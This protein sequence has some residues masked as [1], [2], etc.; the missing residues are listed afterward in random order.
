MIDTEFNQDASAF[1]HFNRFYTQKV[2][3]LEEDYLCSPLSLSKVRVLY[4]LAHRRK[5]TSTE[6]GKVLGLDAG[7]LSRIV[8][9]FAQEGLID[10]KPSKTDGRQT[11]LRLTKQG[12]KIFATLNARAEEKA[13]TILNPLATNDRNR[14]FNAMRTVESVLGGQHDNESSYVLRTP[15]AG[16]LGWIVHRHGALY[17]E[18]YGWDERFEALVAGIIAGFVQHHDDKRERCWIAEKDGEIVGC[19]FLV[20]KS[21]T[22]AQLRLLLVEPKERGLGIGTRLVDECTAFAR[23][24]GY[25]SIVLWTNSVLHAARHT[26]EKAGYRL[27]RKKHHHSFGHDLIGETWEL[28]L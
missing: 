14:L 24:T 8:N 2:G 13:S 4:E 26:Y 3:V 10:S 19:V 6:I 9:N 5:A 20:K 11:I 7:Y 18:E 1:R 15:H 28:K 27:V 22:V 23:S 21:A 17:F 12:L 25:R 16:D